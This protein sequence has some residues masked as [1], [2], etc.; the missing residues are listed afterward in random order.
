MGHRDYGSTMYS[1]ELAARASGNIVLQ[2]G[3]ATGIGQYTLIFL[4]GESPSLKE[5]PGRPQSTES[6]KVGH[7]QSDPAHIDFF[8]FL[9]VAALS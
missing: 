4:P 8:F 5:K 7:Y 1:G 6:Q 2:K 9:L 3:M